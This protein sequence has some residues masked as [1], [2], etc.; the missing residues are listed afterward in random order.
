MTREHPHRG[1]SSEQHINKDVVL[2]A[3]AIHPRQTILDAG[4]GNGY[5][6]LAFAE[7][8]TSQGKV[9]AVDPDAESIENLKKKIGTLPIEAM[10][11]D[12]TRPLAIDA[13]SLDMI[14]LSTVL[15]GFSKDQINGFQRE[16]LRLLKPGGRLA[17]VEIKKEKTPFGPPVEMRFSPEELKNTIHLAPGPYVEAGRYLYLQIFEKK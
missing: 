17:I 16:V 9:V 5:M 13:L 1:K 2:S 8:L 14:Y 12:I 3:L 4:C 6:S 15:H 7:R 10:A 11:A